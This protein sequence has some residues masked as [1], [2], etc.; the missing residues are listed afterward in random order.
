VITEMF[1][2]L[3][4]AKAQEVAPHGLTTLEY[5]LLWYCLEGERTATEL[6]QVLPV[7]GSRISRVVTGLVDRGLLRRRRLRNDR[8]I[9][10]LSLTEEGRETTSGIFG[11]MRRYYAMLT[12]D[13]DEEELRAFSSVTA[14][15]VAKLAAVQGAE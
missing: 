8:R 5:N 2:A 10:M 7:D 12:K 6:A 15:I 9:V 13:I 4:K 3:D 14:R 11:N 1:N